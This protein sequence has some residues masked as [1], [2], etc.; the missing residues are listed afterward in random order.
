[1]EKYPKL[2]EFYNAFRTRDS[3]I[4]DVKQ[5]APPVAIIGKMGNLY[6]GNF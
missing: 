5:V 3:V 4:R 2:V 1:M 6:K